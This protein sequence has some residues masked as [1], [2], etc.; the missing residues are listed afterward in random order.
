LVGEND[1]RKIV[2]ITHVVPSRTGDQLVYRGLSMRL[3]NSRYSVEVRIA[4]NETTV[5]EDKMPYLVEVEVF[6]DSGF[7]YSRGI[8]HMGIRSQNKNE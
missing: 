4:H 6:A 8:A 7:K 2:S 5:E 1:K 3:G